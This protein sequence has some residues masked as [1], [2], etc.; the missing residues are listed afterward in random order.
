M[1]AVFEDITVA[2]G[3]TPLVQINKLG[4]NSDDYIIS[5]VR[6]ITISWAAHY[7]QTSL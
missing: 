4:Q 1:S 7:G 2:V 3:F 5:D 6:N